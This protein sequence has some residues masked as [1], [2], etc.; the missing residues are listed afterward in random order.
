MRGLLAPLGWLY[1]G[2][3]RLRNLAFDRGVFRQQQVDVPVISVG[4]LNAGGTGKT[5]LVEHLA[6]NFLRDKY[7][8][9]VVS[10]GYKRQ[11]SGQVIVSRGEGPVVSVRE[12]GD[13]PYML[14][15]LAPEL[16]VVV[17]ADRV[18]GATTLMRKFDVDIILMD[19]GFQHRSLARDIDIVI[20]P[21]EDLV[22]KE[23]VIPAGRLREPWSGLDRATHVL[24]AEE[25]KKEDSH[26]K[27]LHKYTD[28]H[29]FHGKKLTSS[30]LKNPVRG[31]SLP[32]SE[33]EF[34]SP[35]FAIA[36]IGYPEKFQRALRQ[37]PLVLKTFRR[38]PDHHYYTLKEQR[39]LLTQMQKH[40]AD[41]LVMTAKDFVKWDKTLLAE[42]PVYYLS[43]EYQIS[44]SLYES[45]IA[46][47]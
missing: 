46:A 4:N 2:A 22:T 36:G 25:N 31:E 41:M 44:P 11:S 45:V 26:E 32:L 30:T 5:P 42:N 13:E 23:S 7:T 19:D 40:G 9:G 6:N 21:A 35:V 29:L 17:N 20:V 28:A 47:L 34:A 39:D 33:F 38:Y 24:I 15:L 14:S 18:Q 43:V 16:R 10:R 27:I 12:A 1:G 37:L 8:V 3:M